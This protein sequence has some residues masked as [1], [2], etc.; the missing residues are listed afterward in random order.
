L[1]KKLYRKTE[2]RATKSSVMKNAS[3]YNIDHVI[4]ITEYGKA[5]TKTLNAEIY[6]EGLIGPACSVSKQIYFMEAA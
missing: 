1:G 2:R 3:C 4:Y 5:T 6:V